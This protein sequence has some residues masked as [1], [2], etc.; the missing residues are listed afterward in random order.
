MAGDENRFER[1]V[2]MDFERGRSEAPSVMQELIGL[3][4]RQGRSICI[5]PAMAA[6]FDYLET[7]LQ[8]WREEPV[9]ISDLLVSGRSREK[10]PGLV[11]ILTPEWLARFDEVSARFDVAIVYLFPVHAVTCL[12]GMKVDSC[13]IL[14]DRS[15]LAIENAADL[16]G[17]LQ[18]HLESVVTEWVLL[19]KFRPGLV[20]ERMAKLSS[21]AQAW[22]VQLRYLLD[23]PPLVLDETFLQAPRP[24]LAVAEER[25]SWWLR[26]VS[27]FRRIFMETVEG[28]V[29]WVGPNRSLH[30][31]EWL[32]RLKSRPKVTLRLTRSKDQL[33]ARQLCMGDWVRVHLSRLGG[34]VKVVH[35]L[36]MRKSTHR[37]GD[38]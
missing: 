26:L 16:L 29:S 14:S 34:D 19:F 24:P 15:S 32:L 8:N 17:D 9:V 11:Y 22:S 20:P 28:P 30:G 21:W 31:H 38:L 2:V 13:F 12:V 3:L 5:V 1:W 6:C 36:E 37:Q 4:S 23:T 25:L 27:W 18:R 35:G 33:I 10:E 7:L